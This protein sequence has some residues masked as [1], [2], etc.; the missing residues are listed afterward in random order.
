[1]RR[2]NRSAKIGIVLVVSGLVPG[3]LLATEYR[4]PQSDRPSVSPDGLRIVYVSDIGGSKDLWTV[5]SNGAGKRPFV[6][7][8]S[9]ESDPDWAPD[10]SSVI[11]TSNRDEV[12]R[13]I[14]KVSPDGSAPTRLT[15]AEA[16]HESPRY[17]PDGSTIM[18][19]SDQTGKK[20]IWL[21]KSDGSSPSPLAL[22]STRVSDPA[23]SPDGLAITYVGC[24][25]A[26]ECNLYRINADASDG[27]R[28]TTGDFQDWNPDWG[29]QGIVFASN[30]GGSQGLWVVQPDGAGMS[31]I[32]A[33]DGAADLDPRWISSGGVVFSRSGSRPSDAASDIW[34]IESSGAPPKRITSTIAKCDMDANGDIDS[35]DIRLVTALRGRRV[36]PATDVADYDDNQYINVNDA[37]GCTLACT[38]PKCATN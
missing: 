29:P 12:F 14:W 8:P 6:N 4:Q 36:P 1:M 19:V 3:A 33:P 24:Q 11:F 32:T 18:Y 22:I 30:R 21:M 23:W 38:R 16:N 25:R 15:S 5:G 37:R 9:D 26:A 2:I 20:E 7:W 17:S 10:G 31:Q 28:V 13:H 35:N 34:L 27:R